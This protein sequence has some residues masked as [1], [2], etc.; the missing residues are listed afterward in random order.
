M[1]PG[2]PATSTPNL[3]TSHIARDS[4]GRFTMRAISE[5]DAW[6][7]QPRSLSMDDM[8]N[9]TFAP[10]FHQ[11]QPVPGDLKRRMTTPA[12]LYP[13]PLMTTTASPISISEPMSAPALSSGF[14]PHGQP[15]MFAQPWEPSLSAGHEMHGFAKAPAQFNGWYSEPQM[16]SQVQEEDA[17]HQFSMAQSIPYSDALHHIAQ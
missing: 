16:L 11:P 10:T 12:E 8:P 6:T 4:E 3:P 5:E 15:L 9:G 2:Y 14:A 7:T 17:I 13:P 1:T